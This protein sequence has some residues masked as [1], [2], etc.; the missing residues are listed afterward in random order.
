VHR[1]RLQWISAL[2]QAISL[3]DCRQSH[4]RL[5]ATNRRKQRAIERESHREEQKRRSSQ[6]MDIELAKAQLEAEK[7]ARLA[8]EMQARELSVQARLEESRRRELEATRRRLEELLEEETRAK[9]D[10]EI[11]RGLQVFLSL[12]DADY[13]YY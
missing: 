2:Q 8:A 5:L 9:R 6:A 1:T 10:E 11:V 12:L 4:Q 3:S 13:Y 7:T